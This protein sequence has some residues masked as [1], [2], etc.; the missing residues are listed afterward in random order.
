MLDSDIGGGRFGQALIVAVW[1]FV[2][3][4]VALLAFGISQV[5]DMVTLLW[6][7]TMVNVVL[8]VVKMGLAQLSTHPKALMAD[9]LHGMGDT[10]AEVVTAL[11]YTEAARPPD[12]EH[13]WGHGKIESIG[14]V[15]VTC[16]LLYI[17]ASMGWDSVAS[18]VPLFWQWLSTKLA[19]RARAVLATPGVSTTDPSCASSE[20]SRPETLHSPGGGARGGGGRES[21]GE[22]R[23]GGGRWV[24]QA[25]IA[26]TVTSVL[27]KEALFKS[28]LTVGEQ[29]ESNLIVA[30]AWHHR[31]DS[32]AAGVALA[33]QLGTSLG[34]H[35]LDPLGSGVVASMLAHSAC[36]SLTESLNDLIDF[37]AASDGE[38]RSRCGRD[39]LSKSIIEVPGVR[40]HTLRTRRMGP[41]CLV[42][43]TIVVDARI[44]ASAAS[45]IAE[46]VHDR[47][48]GDHKPFVTDVTVHV[49]PEGSPQSH[50]LETHA[51]APVPVASERTLSPEALEAQVREALLS[52]ADERPDL[53]R[54]AE[55]TELQSYYYIEEPRSAAHEGSDLA[56][57][58]DVKVDVRLLAEDVTIRA[59]TAVARAARVRVLSALPGVVRDIDMDLE[60]SETEETASTHEHVDNAEAADSNIISE[61]SGTQR[62]CSA[63]SLAT[64]QPS[65]GRW[66][67]CPGAVSTAELAERMSS[68]ERGKLQRV[69][70]IW[71]RGPESREARVPALRHDQRATW[72]PARA[73]TPSYLHSKPT[74]L[75]SVAGIAGKRDAWSVVENTY[76]WAA[77]K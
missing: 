68:R 66:D 56:P 31:S 26:V 45:V 44:S 54:I 15:L 47:V 28:T 14:A 73:W 42:D 58:V 34:Q 50:R 72:T 2:A 1:M 5:S 10:V 46:A 16:I 30:N 63:S 3:V 51:E 21:G 20:D 70:L 52:L 75:N 67:P 41:Y 71:E 62:S 19:L 38:T 11:A 40:N 35:Y 24:R 22:G 74:T 61:N 49:D 27:L 60:L 69:T 8:S 13:P 76:T 43:T 64:G 37:N 39:V 17:S 53:P 25:A 33:S 18:I 48:V 57:Y 32:L 12:R 23:G 77:Q 6:L 59:A 9:A 29:E 65:H 7:G 4:L 36:V 55:V